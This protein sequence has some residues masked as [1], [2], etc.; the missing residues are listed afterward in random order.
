MNLLDADTPLT[1][2]AL[3]AETKA[4]FQ[5]VLK[6]CGSP[7][8]LAGRV[9][10]LH[11]EH[12]KKADII[13]ESE[14][15]VRRIILVMAAKKAQEL[16]PVKPRTLSTAS[17][18]KAGDTCPDGIAQNSEMACRAIAQ[19]RR[20]GAGGQRPPGI[21]PNTDLAPADPAN[22]DLEP[23][24][25][26]PCYV[27]A[28]TP[29][30][31]WRVHFSVLRQKPG[32]QPGRISARTRHNRL[33]REKKARLEA[34]G[35]RKPYTPP[36]QPRRYMMTGR[37]AKRLE[38]VNRTINNPDPVILRTARRMQRLRAYN[39]RANFPIYFVASAEPPGRGNSL[40]WLYC[41][42]A[43][44]ALNP[45]AIAALKYLESG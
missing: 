8:E 18:A 13:R 24:P 17:P 4:I 14:R 16:P 33:W 20:E 29:A 22:T 34:A 23:F 25:G 21:S 44:R 12:A 37:L 40:G 27:L 36:F 5:D 38:A 15:L 42:D 10:M 9:A 39:R 28:N 26:L 1:D 11:A 43:I 31:Q 45:S 6:L 32:A 35:M 41:G 3:W 7:Q 19:R 30:E 2:A